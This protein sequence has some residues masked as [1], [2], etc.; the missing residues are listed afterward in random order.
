[1]ILGGLEWGSYE[2]YAMAM[3]KNDSDFRTVVNNVLMEAIENGEYF[4]LYEKWFG[5]KSETPIR[6]SRSFKQFMG[7]QVV[8]K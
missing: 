4:T 2:P 1:M 5:S 8:P 3:R 6:M 7:Y